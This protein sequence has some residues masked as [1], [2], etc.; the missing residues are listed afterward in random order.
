MNKKHILGTGGLIAVLGLLIYLQVHAWKKFDWATFWRSLADVRWSFVLLAVA[1]VYCVYAL[2]AVRWRV[3]LKPACATTTARMLAPQFIG[4]AGLALLGRPGEMIRP[5]LVARK[6]NLTFSSQVAVWLVE[7]IFDMGSVA[8]LFAVEGFIGDR[9][10]NSL[11]IA[12]LHRK[13]EWS[14][15]IFLVVILGLS[16]GAVALRFSGESIARYFRRTL[17]RYSARLAAAVSSKISA[18]TDGLRT[19]SDVPSFLQLLFLSLAMWILVGISYWLVIHAYGGPLAELGPASILLLM[20]GAMFGSLI[21]L[22]GVGGGS[23]LATIEIL[24]KVFGI[25]HELAVSC[26]MLIWVA[27]FMS[28][29][30][31]G[32]LFAHREHVSLR[33][34][35]KEEQ[36]EEALTD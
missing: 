1:V 21:Q 30:P 34:V 29:I 31:V 32:L 11:P 28:V 18:F 35:A 14:A 25:H 15:S 20:I 27:T 2:R 12:G 19:I 17:E 24:N 16:V 36:K 33:A 8:L 23:Q 5:Y 13:V 6:E 7:R 9:L 4:F 10:W 26:G 3:F 22:P